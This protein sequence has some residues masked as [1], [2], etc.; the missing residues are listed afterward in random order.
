MPT[1]TPEELATIDRRLRALHRNGHS[2]NEI[3][4]RLGISPG[5][6]TTHSRRLGLSFDRNATAAAVEARTVDL[7]ARR[8][9][10]LTRLYDRVEK[11]LDRLEAPT[12]DYTLIVPGSA[13][14]GATVT[15]QRDDAPP[16]ADERAHMA[17]ITG[18]LQSAVKLEQV[19]ADGG[20]SEAKSML[21]ALGELLGIESGA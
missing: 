12:Y 9:A 6:V 15:T 1:F 4:K 14:D 19:D 7:K 17:T 11:N 10:I 2:R 5:S 13:E 18:Y 16:S 3:A 21:S 8:K 20:E